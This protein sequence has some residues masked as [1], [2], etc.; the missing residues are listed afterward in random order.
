MLANLAIMHGFEGSLDFIHH[1][2]LKEGGG[3][4]FTG[5]FGER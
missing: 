3:L 5:D 4:C 1:A 2:F